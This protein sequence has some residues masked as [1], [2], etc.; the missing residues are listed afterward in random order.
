MR[1]ARRRFSEQWAVGSE[2][3]GSGQWKVSGGQWPE[4]YG[5]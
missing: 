3:W 1:W 2:Q 5:N 4:V